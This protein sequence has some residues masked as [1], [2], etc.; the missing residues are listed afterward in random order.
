LAK[1]LFFNQDNHSK[2]ERI[3]KTVDITVHHGKYN[4][5]YLEYSNGQKIKIVRPTT[6]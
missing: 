2:S 6:G 5:L 3:N 4:Y 1:L